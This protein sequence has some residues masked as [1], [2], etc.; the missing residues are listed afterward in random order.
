MRFSCEPALPEGLSMDAENGVISGVCKKEWDRTVTVR[1][2]NRLGAAE[3]RLRLLIRPD[4][5]LQTP[6][7]G[8]TSWNAFGE[9]VCQADI[10]RT[11]V[12][13]ARLGLNHFG[14]Q[15]INIDSGWQGHIDG[16]TRAIAPNAKFPDMPGLIRHIHGL[17]L[18]AGIYSTPMQKAWGG[19][20]LPGCTTGKL[21]MR[22]ANVYYGVGS[23]HCEAENARQWAEWGLDYLKYDWSPCDPENADLMKKALLESG[24]DFG[25]CVTVNAL[26][27]DAA[28]W[29]EHCSSWRDNLDSKADW[30]NV[31]DNRFSTDRWA[32]CC[33][34]GHFFDL[35]MLE[36]GSQSSGPAK[37]SLTEDEQLLAFTIRAIF[38]S[39]L[40]ISCDVEKLTAFDLALLCNEEVIAVNQDALCAGAVC[41]A[42]TIRHGRD[43]ALRSW[44]KVYEKPLEDG[45]R[46]V[47]LFN[48]GEQAETMALDVA[49]ERARDCWAQEDLSHDGK[50]EL[51]LPPHSARLIRLFPGK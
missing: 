10:E 27:Q 15:Y 11:A 47:A 20:D 14:Y 36:T 42:E 8:F 30:E 3:K 33:A 6:L 50:L 48:L 22:Y 18:K 7:M 9:D 43:R 41:T 5:I 2:E 46:A 25:F 23:E 38:P 44:T 17:G 32:A 37:G 35:D 1:A 40:Q 29:K 49:G 39:P 51:S 4:G 13:V 12:A 24:R 26:W 31:R 34:P 16:Q 28:Y 19:P 21:D 45:G